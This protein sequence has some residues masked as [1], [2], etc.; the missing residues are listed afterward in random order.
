MAEPEPE[1]L[2]HKF[3]DTQPVPR[4][5]APSPGNWL[6]ALRPGSAPCAR[7]PLLGAPFRVASNLLRFRGAQ[8]DTDR[9]PR[10]AHRPCAQTRARSRRPMR[11]SSRTSR[12]RRSVR[13]PTRSYDSSSTSGPHSPPLPPPGR[14][15]F[16]PQSPPQV[17][18]ACLNGSCFKPRPFSVMQGQ[19]K[20]LFVLDGCAGGQNLM[21]TP[22]TRCR[23]FTRS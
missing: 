1:T 8:P 5:G 6:P 18:L 21:W 10:P 2:E 15:L 19:A 4:L 13:I 16:I 7:P 22:Q 14:A 11:P 20:D 23:K 12:R 9:P 17:W 3:W